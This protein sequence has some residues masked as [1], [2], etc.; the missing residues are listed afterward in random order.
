M[1]FGHE[2]GKYP[3]GNTVLVRGASDSVVIDPAL[4]ARTMDPPLE[5]GTVLLT[6]P[7]E[8]HAAGVSAVTYRS[9]RV[10]E[11][12]LPAL[13]TLEGL[14]ELYGVPTEQWPAMTDLVTGRFHFDGWPEAE[15]LADG[16]VLDL[17]GVTVEAVHAPGHTGGHTVYVIDDGEVRVMVTGDIDLT[18]FGPYYGDAASSLEEFEATLAK[19]RG[20]EADHYVTFHHKGVIDGHDEFVRMVDAYAAVFARREDTLRG[21]LAGPRTFDELVDQG[22]V[23]RAGT[24]PA[25]FGDSVER[26][27]IRRHLDRLLAD[28]TAATDGQQYWLR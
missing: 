25:L 20:I 27:S 24:R 3:D 15:A 9:L 1:L 5:V 18:T 11:R 17:G 7:H 23:Y 12:D 22:I 2:Q 4:S 10:H 8:D 28:G 6:H 16:D 13:Q 14:M 19:V 21:L 26:Y